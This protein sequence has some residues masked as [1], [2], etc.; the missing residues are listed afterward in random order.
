MQSHKPYIKLVFIFLATCSLYL[1]ACFSR[2]TY[3]TQLQ[4]LSAAGNAT[5]FPLSTDVLRFLD[6]GDISNPWL[7]MHKEFEDCENVAADFGERKCFLEVGTFLSI[8]TLIIL[9]AHAHLF[10][11]TLCRSCE[12]ILSKN[13]LPTVKRL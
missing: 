13:C 12:K 2:N 6:E 11:C 3:I 4:K 5:S 1:N 9:A 7:Y 8:L 10:S